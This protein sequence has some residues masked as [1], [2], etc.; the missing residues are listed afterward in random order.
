[1]SND[2]WKKTQEEATSVPTIRKLG[3]HFFEIGIAHVVDAKDVKVWVL[4]DVLGD[5]GI[6]AEVKFVAFLLRLG[7]VHHFSALGFRHD[8][9]KG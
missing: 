3:A 2:W 4:L 1:M 9:G 6:L 7:C 8:G 5:V